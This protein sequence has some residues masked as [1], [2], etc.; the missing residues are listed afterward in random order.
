[1]GA[2]FDLKYS[3]NLID[4][5]VDLSH[6]TLFDIKLKLIAGIACN[7]IRLRYTFP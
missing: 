4:F 2:S 3:K 1:M 6:L 5:L 7:Y